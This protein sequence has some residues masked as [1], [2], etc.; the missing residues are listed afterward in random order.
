[1]LEFIDAMT[2]RLIIFGV[3]IFLANRWS[4][5]SMDK[6]IKKAKQFKKRYGILTVVLIIAWWILTPSGMPDDFITLYFINMVGMTWYIL[7]IGLLTAYIIYRL[8]ITL[9]IYR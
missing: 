6:Q 3:M 8:R 1:M 9:V 4:S 2:W 7:T 5:G